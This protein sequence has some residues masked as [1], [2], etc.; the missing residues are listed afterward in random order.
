MDTEK[1]ILLGRALDKVYSIGFGLEPE[2]ELEKYFSEKLMVIGTT[3]DEKF[4]SLD[5]MR[6]LIAN[7]RK[8]SQGMDI[9]F[10]RKEVFRDFRG[11]G[12]VAI[13]VEDLV[14]LININDDIIRL[15]IR[16]SLVLEFIN[17]QWKLVHWHASKPEMVQSEKD[18]FGIEEWKQKT[19]TLEKL[20]EERTA[21]LINKNRELE[22]ESSLE[23]VRTVAMSMQKADDLLKVSEIMYK[24]LVA[25]GFSGMRNALV[26]TFEEEWGKV[27][28]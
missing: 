24:E 21:D 25:L 26:Q 4:S 6:G 16:T 28:R 20:V 13:V 5:G 11:N 15:D 2:E 17:G 10:E 1:E 7:Q 14:A 22:I 27:E 8:Q 23:R 18:T 9:K 3:V 19:S 12:D